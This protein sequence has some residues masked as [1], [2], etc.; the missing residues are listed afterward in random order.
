[1][2]RLGSECSFR[3]PE[4]ACGISAELP[5]WLTGT[6]HRH[7]EILRVFNRTQWGKGILTKIVCQKNQG[8]IKTEQK[9]VRMGD[10]TTYGTLSPK[11]THLQNR[12]DE[13]SHFRKVP[14]KTWISHTHILC[15]CE[16]IA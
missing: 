3:R 1:L 15:D 14:R 13:G 2:A 9:Q 4:P 5:K 12:F 6:W 7:L 16:A 11:R 10:G 8:T